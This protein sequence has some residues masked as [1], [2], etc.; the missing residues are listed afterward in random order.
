MGLE[1]TGDAERVVELIEAL[2]L[3]GYLAPLTESIAGGVGVRE[4][5][6]LVIDQGRQ[7]FCLECLEA[8][9]R[10]PHEIG[11]FLTKDYRGFLRLH[12]SYFRNHDCNATLC[13]LVRELNG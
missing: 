8:T 10:E 5:D 11:E 3:G 2:G 6:D 7:E 4:N 9:A 12:D 13:T 1:E